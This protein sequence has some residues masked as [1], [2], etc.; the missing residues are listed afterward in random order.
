MF[1]VKIF[2]LIYSKQALYIIIWM[3]F[4]FST[5]GWN[6]KVEK[7]SI[8]ITMYQSFH[9]LILFS[10]MMIHLGFQIL[11]LRRILWQ[12]VFNWISI[13]IVSECRDY[14]LET[15][16][17][18][19]RPKCGCIFLIQCLE[20]LRLSSDKDPLILRFFHYIL[21]ISKKTLLFF[22]W[23]HRLIVNYKCFKDIFSI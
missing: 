5:D 11:M 8:F 14:K 7:N 15:Y 18:Y 3:T 23:F 19:L 10:F 17:V 16:K 9:E 22:N 12:V 6:G 21:Y 1:F 13:F 20:P 2:I 4:T